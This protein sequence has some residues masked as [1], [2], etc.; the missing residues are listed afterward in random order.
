M[1]DTNQD[2]DPSSLD[3]TNPSK[4]SLAEQTEITNLAGGKAYEAFTPE[5]GLFKLVIN[6]L[7]EDTY[8]EDVGESVRKLLAQFEAT[9]DTSPSFPLKLATYARQEE[10]FRDISQLL[11]VLSANNPKAKEHV[12]YFTPSIVDR[13]D[14]FNTVVS[15][16]IEIFGKPI[17]KPLQKGMEDALHKKYAI[18]E[19]PDGETWRETHIYREDEPGLVLMHPGMEVV[20]DGYVFDEYT[21][22]KYR[23]DDKEV[24]LYDVLNLVRPKPRSEDRQELFQ[25]IAKGELDEGHVEKEHWDQDPTTDPRSVEPLR[26]DRT[27]EAERSSDT[28]TVTFENIA[29]EEIGLI[30][31]DDGDVSLV[32]AETESE[33]VSMT[34]GTDGITVEADLTEA[35]EWRHRLDDMG[36]MARVRNLRNMLESGLSGEEIFDYDDG[37]FGPESESRVREH[38]QFPFRYYQAFRACSDQSWH[39]YADQ[40][41]T[42]EGGVLDD[43]SREWLSQAID[44]SIQ[45]LPET[46][47]N[48]F[49]AIDLSGSMNST[50]SGDSEMARAEIA[51]LFGAMLLR[52]HSDSGAFGNDFAVFDVPEQVVETSST[53]DLA[54]QIYE[55]SDRVGNST[56]GWKALKWATEEGVEYDRFV[57]FTDMQIWDSTGG[58]LFSSGP[59]KSVKRWWDR[60]TDEVN[61]DAHLYMVDLASYGTLSLPENYQNVHQ[62]GGWSENIIDFIDSYEQAEDVIGDIQSIEPTDY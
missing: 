33:I 12:R 14:E 23:Q 18:V 32:G 26:Q 8:Y 40:T 29:D 30:S 42:L 44:V 50:I 58:S 56:N 7:L 13:M 46:L 6:G 27:W 31:I 43:F 10:G 2:F 41:F 20:D 51:S 47:E 17:P 28:T 4:P 49:T 1:Q 3:D 38:K 60:Y 5:F 54:E 21:A 11:L 57:F 61:P 15:L 62:I 45:N 19:G 37:E 22:S 39:R 36:L 16:Q 34:S 25:K 55:A 59:K 35:D 52:R 24:S 48:T 53:L 9:A